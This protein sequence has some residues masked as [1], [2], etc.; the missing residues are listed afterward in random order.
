MADESDAHE[1]A[2]QSASAPWYRKLFGAIEEAAS[3]LEASGRDVAAQAKRKVT[4]NRI[5]VLV[6]LA[7]GV[8]LLSRGGRRRGRRRA[9][10]RGLLV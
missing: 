2:H 4:T 5:G 8:W 7:A 6:G 9:R 1:N 10:A 3:N